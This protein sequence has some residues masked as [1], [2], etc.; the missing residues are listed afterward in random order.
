MRRCAEQIG[1]SQFE[2]SDMFMR[3]MPGNTLIPRDNSGLSVSAWAWCHIMQNKRN[4]YM[5]QYAS[6]GVVLDPIRTHAQNHTNEVRQQSS[7]G[8][9]SRYH[10]AAVFHV[11]R[12]HKTCVATAEHCIEAVP[13]F[14]SDDVGDS[15]CI[16]GVCNRVSS[17]RS[18]ARSQA[19]GAS[20]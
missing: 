13:Q 1:P 7:P 14:K 12:I 19:P 20:S 4:I 6:W 10:H 8:L 3:L 2:D 9:T 16:C 11:S 18:V 17:T 5:A 15:L